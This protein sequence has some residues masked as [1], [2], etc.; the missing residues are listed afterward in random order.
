MILQA[1]NL[2]IYLNQDDRLLISGFSFSLGKKDKAAVIGE[3][4]NGKSTLLKVLYNPEETEDY[5][6]F[7]GR[8]I[9]KGKLA[10]LP[11]FME[12]TEQAMGV[13]EY[14]SDTALYEQ[15]DLIRSLGLEYDLLDSHRKI[16]SLSGGEKIKLQLLKLLA[17][18]PDALLLDEPSNDLDIDTL[19][20]IETFIRECSVPVLF[21]SHDET[22]ISACA[23]VIIHIEQLIRKTKSSIT[24]SRLSY[25]EYLKYRNL[26]FDRQKEIALKE[27]SEYKKKR[28]RLQQLYEKARHNTSWRN[29][30]GIP[31][32]DGHARKSMQAIIVKGKRFEREKEDFTEIPDRETGIITRF[33][34][35]VVIPSQKRIL[36]LNLPEL[37]AGGNVLARNLSLSV[38]GPQ[39][40]CIIGKNGAGKSTL[41]RIIWETLKDRTDITPAY[42]PQ[43]YR[44]VLDYDKTPAEFLMDSYD[45]E[46]YTRAM[47]FMGTMKFTRE[48]M[49]HKIGDLSG[50]QRAKIIFLGMVLKKADVLVLDEPTR[51]FSPLSAPVIRNALSEFGGTII[52]VS[53]DRKYLDETADVIYELTENG[54]SAVW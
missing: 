52:S 1:E 13:S 31:S 23:N 22:L 49:A 35:T 28:E 15:Y 43:D 44:E 11:Q 30:D 10:Y 2:S 17:G 21:I 41:L 37:A 47:S 20:F 51:N 16:A 34:S 5:V 24:V 46:T 29:P 50:G 32:T 40:I 8:I 12:E 45:K 6:H 42:M 25:E 19:V 54:L 36:D 3:E 48:E 33:D 4:G 26:Q 53:H 27:R 14:L 38:V 39:H 18:K 9:R 7:T